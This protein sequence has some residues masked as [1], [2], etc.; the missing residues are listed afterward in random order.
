MPAS[1]ISAAL[2]RAEAVLTQKPS[3]GLQ[4]DAP[5]QAT[6]VGDSLAMEI[7]HPGGQVIRTD[8]ATTLGGEGSGV[9]PGWLMRASLASCTATLIAMRAEREGIHLNKLEVTARSQSDV[10]GLLGIDDSVPAGPLH[11]DVDVDIEAAGVDDSVLNDLIAWA[12]AHSPI[13]NVV[14]RKVET[15][16]KVHVARTAS[17]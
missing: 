14:R 2:Q 12:D 1:A 7:R 10:R 17:H 3:M 4:V 16:V 8:M 6:R 5:A 15:S 11:I 13:G 9:P